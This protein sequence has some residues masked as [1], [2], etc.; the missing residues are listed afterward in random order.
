VVKISLKIP[1]ILS[2]SRSLLKSKQLL[3]V[4][5]PTHQRI[6]HQWSSTRLLCLDILLTN[7]YDTDARA[8][9]S[10]HLISAN[11]GGD[12]YTA[13]VNT[14]VNT[15][16]RL[17]CEDKYSKNATWKKHTV[18]RLIITKRERSV[19]AMHTAGANL[20]NVRRTHEL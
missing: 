19:V 16:N 2:W 15:I 10:K 3:L 6:F 14:M 1:V 4:T 12:T 7:R 13:A 9:K 8:D 20:L 11:P 18:N 17:K 5:Y